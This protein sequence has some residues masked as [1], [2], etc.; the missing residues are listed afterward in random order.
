ME[1]RKALESDC[2]TLVELYQD[3][4]GT[5]NGF[6]LPFEL[7]PEELQG[8]LAVMLKSKLCYIAVAIDEGRI[9]AFVSAGINRMDRKLK[10]EGQVMIG[11]INDIY[12]SPALR[13]KNVAAELLRLAEGWFK[14]NEIKLVECCV[15][16]EN[17]RSNAFFKKN[18]YHD[19]SRVLYKT[20]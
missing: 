15:I 20:L 14:E 19:L 13:G 11:L 2:G 5:L 8:I 7:Q 12:V 9:A 4:Y 6:G 1:I 3:L 10:H 18:G 17:H 16:M